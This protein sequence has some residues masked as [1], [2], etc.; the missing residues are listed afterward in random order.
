MSNILKGI[1]NMNQTGWPVLKKLRV[2]SAGT[3]VGPPGVTFGPRKHPSYEF[4]WIRSSVMRVTIDSAIFK[5]TAGSLFL[6]PPAV[7]DRYD[8]SKKERM[9]TS[10][11]HFNPGPIP[12]EWPPPSQWPLVRQ[13]PLENTLFQLFRQVLSFS[14]LNDNRY[15]PLLKPAVE[16]MLRLYLCGRFDEREAGWEAGLSPA[17]EKVIQ[18]VKRRVEKYPSR[19]IR[20][21]E[22]ASQASVSAQHLCR[23]FS[24]DLQ[25]GPME[26]ARL[27]RADQAGSLLERTHLSVKEISTRCGFE[28]QFHFSKVFRSIYG[29]PPQA[30]RSGYLDGSFKPGT[31]LF[32][33]YRFQRILFNHGVQRLPEPFKLIPKRYRL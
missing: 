4:I 31:P 3:A 17:V 1:S 24:K 15:D 18:W 8:A 10:F 6:V 22:M 5:G 7:I 25:I 29:I 28:N 26:C 13:L 27:L 19:K 30:Y 32:N 12:R 33:K 20:L 16:L 2:D 9:V 11:L 23:L 14:P 21:E